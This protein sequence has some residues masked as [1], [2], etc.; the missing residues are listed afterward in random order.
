MNPEYS[1]VQLYPA[2]EFSL[3]EFNMDSKRN[4][5]LDRLLATKMNEIEHFRY[6]AGKYDCVLNG[7]MYFNLT[8]RGYITH[9]VDVHRDSK[10][11][12]AFIM[13]NKTGNFAGFMSFEENRDF[14]NEIDDL[15]LLN[16]DNIY[17]LPIRDPGQY[18]LNLLNEYTEIRWF[19]RKKNID[20]AHAY[21]T[22]IN[23]LKK[24]GYDAKVNPNPSILH[25]AEN[26]VRD[27]TEFGVKSKN[28]KMKQLATMAS[29]CKSVGAYKHEGF[30]KT[31]TAREFSIFKSGTCYDVTNWA[32]NQFRHIPH[33]CIHIAAIGD[34]VFEK[35]R[36]FDSKNLGIKATY[37]S[38]PI[39]EYND[40]FWVFEA[41]WKDHISFHRFSKFDDALHS[42]ILLFSYKGRYIISKD[43]DKDY[44]SFFIQSYIPDD[45]KRTYADFWKE[46]IMDEGMGSK[47]IPIRY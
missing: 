45:K 41:S 36:W 5:R 3:A 34:Q 39:F 16:F 17:S 25:N 37:H 10:N 8:L 22:F 46:L 9:L 23:E 31:L 13:D 12:P 20:A 32:H 47:V 24:H 4:P 30:D 27:L 6:V 28:S 43:K 2:N 1:E 11:K 38:C 21:G 19:V 40:E 33:T 15:V 42:V 26:L 14:Y 44:R 29:F 7:K 18:V 35:K